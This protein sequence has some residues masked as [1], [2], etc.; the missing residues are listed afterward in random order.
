[1]KKRRRKKYRKCIGVRLHI[2]VNFLFIID[3]KNRMEI[4]NI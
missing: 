2:L 3:N 4:G 1:M